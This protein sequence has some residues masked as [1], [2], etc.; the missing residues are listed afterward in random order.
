MKLNKHASTTKYLFTLIE[1]LIVVAIIGILASL[2]LPSLHKA[3]T[4]TQQ[5]V[6]ISN[7]RNLIFGTIM[8]ADD[9]QQKFPTF[10]VAGKSWVTNWFGSMPT[11]PGLQLGAHQR[12]VNPY[13]ASDIK[14]D[15]EIKV[16]ICPSS[17][18][19][20][21]F[22]KHG[23]NYAANQGLNPG[24]TRSVKTLGKVNE[25]SRFVVISE[26]PAYPLVRGRPDS[27]DF[28]YHKAYQYVMGFADGSARGNLRVTHGR[29]FSDEFTFNNKNILN[30]N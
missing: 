11:N 22:S 23:N 24:S 26:F 5:G 18:A 20:A 25:P 17:S 4:K 3:K 30:K 6:C 21:I 28:I 19:Q 2:L 13:L 9:H 29:L 1:L 15:T 16:A 7:T 12:P 10:K 27:P 8:Y 14:P